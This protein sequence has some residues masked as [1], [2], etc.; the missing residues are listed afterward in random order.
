MSPESKK[1][2]LDENLGV[3]GSTILRDAGWDVATVLDEEL[4]ATDDRT[5][6]EVCRA[7]RRILVT[8]DKDFSNALRYP[9]ARYSGIVVLRL[10]EPLR[11]ESIEDAL[12]RLVSASSQRSLV[13]RLWIVDERRI[14]EF[15]ASES[16]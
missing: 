4:C 6:I 8:L 9:P 13:G 5:L 1:V 12:R 2:K 3:R 10:P 14:R 7:E 15:I 11:R 16:E